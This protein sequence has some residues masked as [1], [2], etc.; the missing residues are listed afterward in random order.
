MIRDGKT[1]RPADAKARK[2]VEY[3]RTQAE[4]TLQ[5]RLARKPT[6][7]PPDM[8]PGYTIVTN[9]GHGG[10][11]RVYEAIDNSTQRRVAIK[12][13]RSGPFGGEAERGR[14]EREIEIL[15]QLQHPNIVTIHSSGTVALQRYFVMDFIEGQPLDEYLTGTHLSIDQTLNVF[16]R[17]C[18]A[19]HAA[20]L[21]GIVHRDL[22]PTNIQIDDLG[23]PYVLDF[24]LAKAVPGRSG[25]TPGSWD[26]TVDGQFVGS[27]PWAA[28]EQVM[29]ESDAMDLRTDVYGLGLLL[30]FMLTRSLPYER[31]A[32]LRDMTDRILLSNPVRPS[33]LRRDVDDELDTIVLMCLQKDPGRRYQIAGEL[34][35]DLRRYRAGEPIEAKRDNARYVLAKTLRRHRGLATLAAAFVLVSL[36]Y[37]VTISVL[38]QR[39]TESER[40]AEQR[41]AD[42]S[43]QYAITQE[44]IGFLVDEVS[45]KLKQTPG[46]TR[47]RHDILDG[48][49]ERLLPLVERHGDDPLLLEDLMRAHYQLGDLAIA[50]AHY[51]KA[52]AHLEKALELRLE[53]ASEE[54]STP[55]ARAELS[56]HY[57]LLGDVARAREDMETCG[58][59]YRRA[60]AI[61]EQLV[62]DYP[63]SAH[64]QDNL[65]WSY[66]RLGSLAVS[67]GDPLP[68]EALFRKQLAI[69]QRLVEAS[70]NNATRLHGLASAHWRLSTCAAGRQD[71]PEMAERLERAVA[72]GRRML[73]VGSQ[74]P[75]QW[76]YHIGRILNYRHII[77]T[78][79]PDAD[80]DTDALLLE[81]LNLATR[82]IEFDPDPL[83]N[84][85]M[86]DLTLTTLGIALD[87]DDGDLPGRYEEHV[88]KMLSA[89]DDR[90]Q[91]LSLTPHLARMR[92][93][94]LVYLAQTRRTE[95]RDAEAAEMYEKAVNSIENALQA[96]VD[97]PELRIQL[98][99]LLQ[100][101]PNASETERFAAINAARHS[102]ESA[103]EPLPEQIAGVGR[104]YHATGHLEA[105]IEMLEQAETA[106][107]QLGS[108]LPEQD[109][110]VLS[111]C[112]AALA[113]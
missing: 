67:L 31:G 69:M 56:I 11:G 89:I 1:D 83:R 32:N 68:A 19:V 30:Y 41:A 36:G 24:G 12:V 91:T 98:A 27:L 79:F 112:R 7:L 20:H 77:R 18:E 87:D 21:R 26:A 94:G 13:L 59:L 63:D 100:N 17:I 96:G 44:A 53:L 3:A 105:A 80:T 45:N 15:A 95:G 106:Y 97:S 46:N 93:S 103:V 58:D 34:A 5:A 65:A 51:D 73:E 52:A 70:P 4:R 72:I 50:L 10:Q 75:L 108:D 88:R 48:A 81:A 8:F 86:F 14:F 28:P 9:V 35:R 33:T 60:L 6:H 104:L 38:Y 61:D 84:R 49:F 110:L 76:Y 66:D 39:A 23:E 78:E 74:D 90:L 62:A 2:L 40:L 55:E 71:W 42:V 57:V 92:S 102:V 16:L 101:D 64:F 43:E 113:E 29:N 22:K 99:E 47:V 54:T 25:D 107:Q 109:A 111:Q 37:G 85:N 82:L